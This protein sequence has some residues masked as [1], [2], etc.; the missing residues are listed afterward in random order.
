MC[1]KIAIYIFSAF[2]GFACAAPPEVV[3]RAVQTLQDPEYVQRDG[4]FL[5][6]GMDGSRPNQPPPEISLFQ[7]AS[8]ASGLSGGP[9]GSGFVSTT[10]SLAVAQQW[11]SIHYAG[12]GWI[13]HIL[14][15]PNFY[16]VNNSLGRFSPHASEF[17]Y[18]ALGRV[19]W[20]QVIGWQEV[21]GGT[22]LPFVRNNGYRPRT[23]RPGA[24]E[25]GEPRLAGF[26]AGHPALQQVFWIFACEGASSVLKRETCDADETESQRLGV[27][28]FRKYNRRLNALKLVDIGW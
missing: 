5:P 2:I 15:T 14:P 24:V 20:G 4:G 16:S 12:S 8:G 13:Y 28:L 6:R 26:P 27:E 7:H 1:V 25:A 18:A 9:T 10:S 23:F 17:E 19:H 21:R 11:I 3:F 22:V